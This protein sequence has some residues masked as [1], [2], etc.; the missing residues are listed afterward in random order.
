MGVFDYIQW[1]LLGLFRLVFGDVAQVRHF[2]QH[3]VT[4]LF[5]FFRGFD[6]VVKRWSTHQGHQQGAMLQFQFIRGTAEIKLTR[7]S[8]PMNRPSPVLA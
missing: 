5:R 3:H 6:R 8:K 2:I 4:A 1:L 7:Q